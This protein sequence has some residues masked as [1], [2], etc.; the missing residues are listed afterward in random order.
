MR[1]F[2]I[3]IILAIGATAYGGEAVENPMAKEKVQVQGVAN[4]V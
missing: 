1:L 2:T 4:P 3:L